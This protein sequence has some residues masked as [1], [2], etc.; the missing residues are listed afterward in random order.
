LKLTIAMS[1]HKLPSLEL[2]WSNDWLFTVPL[3]S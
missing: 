3:N 2:Y 1:I